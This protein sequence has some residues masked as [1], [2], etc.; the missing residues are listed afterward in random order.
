MID[1]TAFYAWLRADNPRVVLVH[2][3]F[4]VQEELLAGSPE[5]LAFFST[6][7]VVH[8]A[9]RAYNSED[10]HYF[11]CVRS[12]PAFTRSL[13]RQRLGGATSI[14]FG[15]V[16]I[17]NADGKMDFL[18]GLACDGSPIYFLIGDPNWPREDFR[19]MFSALVQ[20]VS[21]PSLGAIS[22]S[23]RDVGLLIDKSIGGDQLIGGIGPNA[24][25]PRPYNFGFVHN[26]E[27]LLANFGPLLYVYGTTGFVALLGS[28]PAPALN[29]R[30]QGV[31]VVFTDN[32]DGTLN[33]S[34]SPVG[35][36]TADLYRQVDDALPGARCSQLIDEL[37]VQL[38]G[39]G[40]PTTFLGAHASFDVGGANDF[41]VGLRIA[42]KTNLL[43]LLSEVTNTALAFWTVTRDGRFTYGRLWPHDIPGLQLSIRATVMEGDLLGTSG[44]VIERLE[45]TY[46]SVPVIVNKNWTI[47]S[48]FAGAV[49][50][51]EQA[52]YTRKGLY[53]DP[54]IAPESEG[55]DI[56]PQLYHKT[57]A[58]A[59]AQE[60]LISAVDDIAV[61]NA[62]VRWS[63][64]RTRQFLP[65]IEFISVV[66]DLRFFFLEFG[67]AVVLDLKGKL[68]F[69]ELS[70]CQV[71][72]IEIDLIGNQ[73]KLVLVW[74]RP[75]NV[76]DVEYD[77]LA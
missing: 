40:A 44:I 59:P 46:Y 73:V 60:T 37:V 6:D 52:L 72:G 48:T 58:K 13:D 11:D 30:D 74:R 56:Q 10:Q 68:G 25:R 31:G 12:V 2:M 76:T 55:I 29:V 54:I 19:L 3:G 24:D 18:L 26:A 32:G 47:Q 1:D 49:T 66:V 51:E 75:A 7:S 27:C 35:T 53:V 69:D 38:A 34:A 43:D 71:A 70:V 50:V 61:L 57:L 4:R 28:P 23:I 42:D 36:I 22:V 33:L 41:P 16:E 77:D 65:W 8:L 62:A 21:A 5:E 45:P 64:I 39:L 15:T 20:N 14:S 63:E 67:D 17:D 9:T